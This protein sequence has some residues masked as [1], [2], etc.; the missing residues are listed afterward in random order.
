[1]IQRIRWNGW[2]EPHLLRPVRPT[3]RKSTTVHESQVGT[4]GEA[5]DAVKVGQRRH[6]LTG[7]LEDS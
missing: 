1:M 6:T 3:G 2:T 5:I 7:E 4:S